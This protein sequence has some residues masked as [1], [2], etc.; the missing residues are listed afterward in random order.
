MIA[1]VIGVSSVR[2][3]PDTTS[4]TNANRTNTYVVSAFRRT[5]EQLVEREAYLMGTRVRMATWDAARPRGLQRLERAL[6]ILEQTESE[7]STWRSDSTVTAL[8]RTPVGEP[9]QADA[10]LC[11]VFAAIGHWQQETEGAFDPA[12]GS[13]LDAWDVHGRGRVP[14]AP[15]LAAARSISGFSRFGFDPRRCTITRRAEATLDVG[16]FGKGEALDRAARA[17]GD[18]PWMIDFGG[19]VSVHGAPPGESGWSIA[20]AHPSHRD[21]R[22]LLVLIRDG[23]LSTS[24][25]SERDLLVDGTRVGH[26]LD[27]RTGQPAPFRGSVTVWH[28][29]ALVADILSTSLFVMG[30]ERGM[31][32]A[33]ARGLS[34]CYLVPDTD[35]RVRTVMTP[36]FQTAVLSSF[37]QALGPHPQRELL[38]MPRL[39]S[40]RPRLG[41]AAGATS[42]DQ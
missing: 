2:L 31:Q 37:S 4:N 26:I 24:A 16:A 21:R 13:L 7:L 6:A 12:I 14:S 22:H 8:N 28:Q 11:A 39:G 25:G 17:L 23:S 15:E 27:P 36:A 35:G 32:W 38:A 19:Q 34:A 40:A 3:E 18:A 29:R 41:M 5:G 20:I 9:W 10:P 30:P 33:E 42:S 1:D